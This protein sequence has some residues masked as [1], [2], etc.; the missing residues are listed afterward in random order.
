MIIKTAKYEILTLQSLNKPIYVD[1]TVSMF[2]LAL[3]LVLYATYARSYSETV[4]C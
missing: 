2:F 3:N 4:I 1:H